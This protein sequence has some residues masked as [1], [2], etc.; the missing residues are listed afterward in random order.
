MSDSVLNVFLGE[1]AR[2]RIVCR[3]GKDET[4]GGVIELPIEA[5]CDK[6]DRPPFA[7]P[8]CGTK[9]TMPSDLQMD[10]LELLGRVARGIKNHH[11][12]ADVEFVLRRQEELPSG[13]GEK[14]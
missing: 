11:H 12:V 7:C 4:C 6:E 1:L 5:L 2:V 9:F 8:K 3:K 10:Y 14:R 13:G